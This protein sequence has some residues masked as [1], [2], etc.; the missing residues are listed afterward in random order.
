M[1]ALLLCCSAV[2]LRVRVHGEYWC[3]NYFPKEKSSAQH[4]TRRKQADV[5]VYLV[6]HLTNVMNIYIYVQFIV[7]NPQ[8][9]PNSSSGFKR[10]RS[11]FQVNR[12]LSSAA[13]NILH[14][15]WKKKKIMRVF[16][17]GFTI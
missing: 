17:N 5:L 12:V 16:G 1:I 8:C 13:V 2:H 7:Q 10:T 3:C 9:Q 6:V 11:I 4:D 15:G 14:D